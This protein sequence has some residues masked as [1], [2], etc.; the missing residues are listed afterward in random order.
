MIELQ[1]FRV[2]DFPQLIEWIPDARFLLQWAGPMYVWPLDTQQLNAT[3]ER[4][5][6]HRPP[7]YMFKAV[8]SDTGETMGHIEL[9]HVDYAKRTG[10]IGRVLVGP[11][12]RRGL[13]Y[14]KQI[15]SE[16]IGFSF[17]ELEL[18]TL[19]I[20]VFDFNKAGIG[21]YTSIG[22]RQVE[23]RKNARQFRDEYWNIMLMQLNR[24]ESKLYSK[25]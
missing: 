19:T 15:L 2:K 8:D 12:E 24:V 7:H 20:S 17:C 16:L 13:G 1:Q 23:F 22:F 11:S 4:T 6:G 3:L 25:E 18:Q 10:H 5:Y 21:C 9:V 14:G